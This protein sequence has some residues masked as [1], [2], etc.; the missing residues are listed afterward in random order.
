MTK[1]CAKCKIDLRKKKKVINN[2]LE[3]LCVK[4]HLKKLG[5]PVDEPASDTIK[6]RQNIQIARSRSIVTPRTLSV[7]EN[8]I[9]VNADTDSS[10][11]ISKKTKKKDILPPSMENHVIK[12]N[13]D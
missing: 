13:K 12:K 4:C 11:Y 3:I 7:E 1:V 6:G 5:N 2:N 10:K 8:I 9:T